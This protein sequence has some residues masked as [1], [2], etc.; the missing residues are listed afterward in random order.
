MKERIRDKL[1]SWRNQILNNV[2]KE[3]LIK[4]VIT[5]IPAY[6]MC[7]FKLP[8]SWC[9]EINFMIVKFSWGAN[10]G[11]REIHWKRWEAMT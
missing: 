1:Q 4:S 5:V 11:Y 8:T 10:N 9:E 2:G 7:V 6:V 3:V